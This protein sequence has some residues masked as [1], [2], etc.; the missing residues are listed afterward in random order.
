MSNHPTG[1]LLDLRSISTT[2]AE[3]HCTRARREQASKGRTDG[4]TNLCSI[5]PLKESS[6]RVSVAHG[7]NRPGESFQIRDLKLRLV[8]AEI[9]H[10]GGVDPRHKGRDG[11]PGVMGRPI[12]SP[13][14]LDLHSSRRR[15]TGT[16]G[17]DLQDGVVVL[18]S[19]V[20][21]LVGLMG[22]VVLGHMFTTDIRL[23]GTELTFMSRPHLSG[24]NLDAVGVLTNPADHL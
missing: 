23:T 15:G 3:R 13:A 1:V 2:A 16:L 10:E 4:L 7:F 8:P 17:H 11:F 6:R 20:I 22:G 18:L 9:L 12:A 24:A 21:V 14:H 19:I 5:C